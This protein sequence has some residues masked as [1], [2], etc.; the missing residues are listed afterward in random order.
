MFML[1]SA[2]TDQR[3]ELLHRIYADPYIWSVLICFLIIV[4]PLSIYLGF[5]MAGRR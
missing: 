5:R 3:Q 4:I 2:F 1:A